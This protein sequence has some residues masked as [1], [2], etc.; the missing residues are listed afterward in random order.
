MT[1][2][3]LRDLE[4]NYGAVRALRGISLSVEP[5]A[6]VAL[7]GANGA[8]KST[9]QKAIDML[10]LNHQLDKPVKSLSY[11]WRKRVELARALAAEPEMIL[12]DEPVAGCNDEATAELEEIVR[13]VNRNLGVTIL[14]VEHD[15]SMVMK[16][17]DYIY[18]INFG[19]NLADG[20]PAE[21]QA[22]PKVIAAYLG[23]VT[24]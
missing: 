24:Q 20:T 1:A 9:I 2:L 21:V 10:H 13:H 4:V 23:E 8:G 11:G 3:R 14:L 16:V 6:I 17:C 18:V 22:N 7:L 15:M 12:L 5:G 19:A